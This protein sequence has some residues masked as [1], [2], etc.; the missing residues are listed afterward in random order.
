MQLPGMAYDILNML[1]AQLTKRYLRMTA[2]VVKMRKPILR[3]TCFE[4]RKKNTNFYVSTNGV[5]F[6]G[7]L[8]LGKCLQ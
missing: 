5:F 1:H 3:R 7:G 4:I 8:L 2:F 6:E